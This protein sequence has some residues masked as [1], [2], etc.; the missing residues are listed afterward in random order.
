M[1]VSGHMMKNKQILITVG[2]MLVLSVATMAPGSGKKASDGHSHG[3]E[4]PESTVKAHASGEFTVT[5]EILDMACYIDHGARGQGHK[6]CAATCIKSGLPVGIKSDKDGKTYLIIGNHKPLNDKLAEHAA[7]TV[8][9]A[10]KLVERD[11]FAMIE[12]ARVVEK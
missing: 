9:I 6:D 3:H 10:G 8:T 5:G 4:H 2:S 1:K 11:G 7:E 12:N